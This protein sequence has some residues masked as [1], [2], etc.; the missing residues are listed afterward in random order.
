MLF[1]TI[2]AKRF[3]FACGKIRERSVRPNLAM[4]MRVAGAHEFAAIFENLYVADPGNLRERGKLFGP[5]ID[6]AAQFAGVHS[7]NGEIVARGKAQDA[8]QSAVGSG[9]EQTIFLVLQRLGFGQERTKVVLEHIRFRVSRRLSAAGAL[10][11]RAQI[12]AGV[13]SDRRSRR[14]LLYFSLPG[15]LG[16]LRRDQEPFAQERIEAFVGSGEEFFKIHIQVWR[17]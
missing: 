8:A 12:T 5:S 7:W 2:C 4:G 17:P 14:R 6:H 1:R 13:V 9:D 10:V 11:S 15:A 3:I 16:A